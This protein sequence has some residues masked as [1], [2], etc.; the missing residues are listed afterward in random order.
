MSRPTQIPTLFALCTALAA[1]DD[2]AAP[3]P[4]AP[5]PAPA[6]QALANSWTAKRSL[7]PNRT[8]HVAAAVNGRI[9]VAGGIHTDW[10]DLRAF[11]LSRVDVYEIASNSWTRAAG[12]PGVRWAANGASMINGRIYVSGGYNAQQMPTKTLFVYDIGSNKWTRKADMPRGG[13]NGV[14]GVIAGK[15]Y[16]Y[17]PTQTACN[18]FPDASMARLY[19]YDP[20]TDAWVMRANP[21]AS[22]G[23]GAGGV[24]GGKLYIAGQDG[25]L[26]V[27]DPMSNTWTAK[28]PMPHVWRWPDAAVLNGK[29][30]LV[31]GTE[32]AA[33]CVHPSLQVYDPAANSWA[34]RTPPPFGT[35]SGAA[36]GAAGKVYYIAGS[37]Y[38]APNGCVQMLPDASKVIAYT[39]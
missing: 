3:D 4:T 5:G 6:V 29:L 13:C 24:I 36:V 12:L 38:A 2:A 22:I 23:I 8:D 31:G 34:S 39:P 7:A 26:Q 21:P 15:L 30:Y 9:Y 19:R 28:A 1:C 37:E 10:D 17:L 27:Y 18:Q 33:D 35:G 32:V 16:V 14:Q 20:A 11:F 25:G